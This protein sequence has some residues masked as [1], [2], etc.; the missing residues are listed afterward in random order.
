[1]LAHTQAS[2]GLA[3]ESF[4]SGSTL[5]QEAEINPVPSPD[6]RYLAFARAQSDGTM[7]FRGHRYRHRTALY[8]LDL[9][10]GAESKVLDPITKDLTN[11]HAHFSQIFLPSFAW[12]PDSRAI[13]IS[14]DGK[15]AR[16]TIEGF[17]VTDVPFQAQVH[18]VISA[19][20]RRTAGL[21]ADDAIP[22]RFI[23]WPTA[24]PDGRRVVFAALGRLW[25]MD[26]PDGQ[27][28]PLTGDPGRNIQ[29]T[30]A[31]SP[32][33]S[34]IAFASW[35]DHDRGQIWSIDVAR[36]T[37]TRVST[38]P[39]EYIWPTWSPDGKTLV[40]VRGP[41]AADVR[42]A[43]DVPT[44][45]QAVKFS[46]ATA[47][48]LTRVGTPWQPLQIGADERL[49]F[50]TQ[51]D[52]GAAQRV[53]LPY[54]DAVDEELA[55]WI[56]MSVDASGG[57]P[58]I[59]LSFPAGPPDS[60][61]PVLSRDTHRLAYQ[62]DY[63]IFAEKVDVSPRFAPLTHIDPS[64]NHQRL[65]RMRA[66]QLGGVYARWHDNHTLE[67]AAGAEYVTFD[68]NTRAR[69]SVHIPLQFARD[70][71]RGSVALLNARIITLDGDRVIPGGS[72]VVRD[73]RI[74]CLGEC[75]TQGIDHTLD[76]AGKT[77]IPGL[78]DVHDHIATEDSGVVPLRRPS[79]LLD[80]AYGVTTIVDPAVPSTTLFPLAEM[81]EAGKVLGPRALGSADPVYASVGGLDGTQASGYG[82]L[83]DLESR[84][85]ADY[86]V[87][88]RAAWGAVTIKNYR[89]TSRQQQQ[90]LIEAARAHGLS[91][92]AEGDSVLV[93]LG[94]IMDGQTGWEHFLPA[95]PL[96]QDVSQ[97]LGRAGANY[98]PTLSVAGFPDGAIY[99]YRPQFNLQHDPK[100]VRFASAGL[101]KHVTPRDTT[102]PPLD[103]F[104]FPILAE[105]AADI[106]RAGG[107]ATIGEHGENP[108]IGSHWEI[109]AYA[110]AMKPMEALRMATING[111]R[112][113]G[114]ERDVGSLTVGKLA[115]LIVLKGDPL[116]QI[117]NTANIAYVMKSGRLYDAST[118]EPIW[119]SPQANRAS[120]GHVG[121]D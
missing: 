120:E 51:W 98:S 6:G 114:I 5:E 101:L 13:L 75:V 102:P 10:T 115:D 113:V 45:W 14:I 46:G 41:G 44:G 88:R 105:G 82:P 39:G 35:N 89:Q 87:A 47:V 68:V 70:R 18:R 37:V 32:D 24:S 112:S 109:W 33:G 23:Q 20:V 110:T 80:L 86:Q 12:T 116:E 2:G 11:A 67:F 34:H 52:R 50:T 72:I 81:T 85:D 61:V 117:Q 53:E 28:R 97:F 106:M 8:L 9:K 48:V 60:N 79:S 94:M 108:G 119:P 93:D 104:S 121:D 49:Y 21:D 19:Q 96:H 56:V 26:L 58:R 90:W 55:G 36:S 27:P 65:G 95:L 74:T 7:T 16:L 107:F 77:I 3:Q 92:T 62:S 22:V 54:P 83:L 118:L 100:Y 1:M 64:P 99:Y 57:T 63:Q 111:A 40:A 91:V 73:G 4:D 78:I 31:W 15:I 17:H 29:I 66:D 43:W 103:E 30:P 76:L 59:H 25:L 84:A 69:H 42:D 38:E 71:F